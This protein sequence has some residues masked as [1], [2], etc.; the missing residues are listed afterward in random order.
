MRTIS[1]SICMNKADIYTVGGTVQAGSGLYIPRQA[2]QEL[3]TLC[4]AGT[5]AYVL[6]SRQMGKSSLMVRTIE[7][8][9]I[10]GVRC[11]P[12]DLNTIGIQVRP[13]QWYLGL[14]TIIESQLGLQTDV[15]RWWEAHA[16]LGVTQR[17]SSFF[18]S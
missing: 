13:E 9:T 17:L 18:Q 1:R 6:T 14:L 15:M 2:D 12:I 4:R 16:H 8:L 3:L 5:F 11:V 7:R 10:D